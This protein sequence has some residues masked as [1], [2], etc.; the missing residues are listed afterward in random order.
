MQH[1]HRRTPPPRNPIRGINTP[2]SCTFVPHRAKS[3]YNYLKI[4]SLHD[5]TKV[6]QTGYN[7][8][9]NPANTPTKQ[10]RKNIYG[11]FLVLSFAPL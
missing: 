7:L 2:Q 4:S 3:K 9:T 8:S 6:V 1:P 10:A 5:G 11:K